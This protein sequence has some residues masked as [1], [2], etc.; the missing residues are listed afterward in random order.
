MNFMVNINKNKPK[1]PPLKDQQN[2]SFSVLSH[3]PTRNT[4]LHDYRKSS[5]CY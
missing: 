2:L 1:D 4:D 3:I 5:L